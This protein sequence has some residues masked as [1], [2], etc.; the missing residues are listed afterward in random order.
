MML[1]NGS[2]LPRSLVKWASQVAASL[3]AT[4]AASMIYAAL[5]KAVS[6]DAAAPRPELTSG[7]K[8]AAR[9]VDPVAYDGLDT[10]P[11]PRLTPAAVQAAADRASAEA[12]GGVSLHRDAW[13]IPAPSV[14]GP[15]RLTRT[16]PSA[17]AATRPQPRRAAAAETRV[18]VAAAAAASVTISGEERDGAEGGDGLLPRILSQTL[19]KSLS[20]SLSAIPPGIGS[21][22]RAAWALAA[23]AGGSLVSRVVPSVP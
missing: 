10:M 18:V 22:A 16:A 4:L 20:E 7:G 13:D 23:S 6:S 12:P 8:F 1:R 19:P 9:V 17:H 21:G 15:D 3:G 5:P 11:L 14:P 2:V